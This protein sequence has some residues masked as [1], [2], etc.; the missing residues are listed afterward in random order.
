MRDKTKSIFNSEIRRR[1]GTILLAMGIDPR[2]FWLTL[3][4]VP[5]FI[6]AIFHVI[7][8]E[9]GDFDFRI[10]PILSDVGLAAGVARGHYF[11]Q[12]LWAARLIYEKAPKR[13]LDVGSRI[14]GF[15]S[16][17]LVFR[18]VEVIDIRPIETGVRGLKFL[19]GD[20]M[21]GGMDL[22][23]AE[24]VSSLHAIEH[25]GLGR[26]G[27]PLNLNGWQ[28]GLI[29]ISELVLPNGRLYLSVPI[30][31]RQLIELNAQRLF[32]SLTIPAF[33]SELGF[34]LVSYSVINDEGNFHEDLPLSKYEGE[35]GCGCY[36]FV[37]AAS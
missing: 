7:K 5:Q 29:S 12:D 13:H 20:M 34:E 2:R 8:R 31:R 19:E 32:C 33:L 36:E 14:D 11:H 28:H 37:K 6:W 16:H 25:F 3:K 4:N 22:T 24:S 9:K 30:S 18:D 35:F 26:Y 21:S 10:L 23:P 15:I 1:V 27:D 17:L